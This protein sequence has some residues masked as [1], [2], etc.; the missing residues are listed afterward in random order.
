MKESGYV[1]ETDCV[2][3]KVDNKE[4]EYIL[5]SHSEK[6]A[7]AFGLINTFPGTPI[8]IIKNLRVCSDCHTTTKFISKIVDREIILRD[9]TRFH[10]FKNGCAH[11]G[12]TGNGL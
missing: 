5:N 3:Y 2:I 8:L 10:H 4:K 1:P 11:V 9:A 7:I 12:I 6:L